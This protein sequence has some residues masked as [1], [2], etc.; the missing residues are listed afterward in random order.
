MFSCKRL[1]PVMILHLK[2][3]ARIKAAAKLLKIML[4]AKY[5]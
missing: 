2:C 4:V 5:F 1:L 3:Y